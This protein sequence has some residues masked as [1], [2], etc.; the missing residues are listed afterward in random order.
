ME[1]EVQG[2]SV[3]QNPMAVAA[4]QVQRSKPGIAS[5]DVVMVVEV[6]ALKRIRDN[7]V[8]HFASL[9]PNIS[10]CLC[11][12]MYCRS[13][14]SQEYAMSREVE[15]SNITQGQACVPRPCF[16]SII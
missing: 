3:V 16:K 4:S 1:S 9:L 11:R 5:S 15:V 14:N 10:S 13:W 6:V 8:Q 12:Y 2:H 7:P